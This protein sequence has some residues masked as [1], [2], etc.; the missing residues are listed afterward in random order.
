MFDQ[1]WSTEPQNRTTTTSRTRVRGQEKHFNFVELRRCMTNFS[2]CLSSLLVFPLTA[3]GDIRANAITSLC[4]EWGVWCC[5]NVRLCHSNVGTVWV[6]VGKENFLG[7]ERKSNI[8][9]SQATR[10]WGLVC[11]LG[12]FANNVSGRPPVI[13]C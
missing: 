13:L 10:S 5:S 12:G 11:A 2:A 3:P 7:A 9:L 6:W 1:V 8:K 4:S